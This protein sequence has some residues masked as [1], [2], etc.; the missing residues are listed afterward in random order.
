MPLILTI[1]QYTLRSKPRIAQVT[2]DAQHATLNMFRNVLNDARSCQQA[3]NMDNVNLTK[4]PHC[5]NMMSNMLCLTTRV[6][7][8]LMD[9]RLV[10]LKNF[11]QMKQI[12]MNFLQKPLI[13][14]DSYAVGMLVCNSTMPANGQRYFATDNDVRPIITWAYTRILRIFP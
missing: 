6:K 8:G 4:V 14:I 1:Q 2:F 10:K 3:R 9:A 5:L 11:K 13:G 7:C 12:I